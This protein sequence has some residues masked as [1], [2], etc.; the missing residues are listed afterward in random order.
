VLTV[1]AP[2]WAQHAPV[3]CGHTLGVHVVAAPWNVPGHSAAIPVEHVPSLMQHAPVGEARQFDAAHDT[4]TCHDEIPLHAE[5]NTDEH[6]PELRLQHA[7]STGWAHGFGWQFPPTAQLFGEAHVACGPPTHAPVVGLQH[8]PC[9][10]CGHVFVGWQLPPR[11]HAVPD[12][13]L[14]WIPNVHAPVCAL[15][16]VPSGGC[17]HG[18]GV[19][20]VFPTV[21]TVPLAVHW[22]CALITHPPVSV[23]QQLPIGGITHGFGLHTAPLVHTLGA[24]QLT[25][26]VVEHTPSCVQQL[27]LEGSGHTTASHTTDPVHTAGAAHCTWKFCV[28]VPNP[29]LQHAPVGGT[30]HGFGVQLPSCVQPAPPAHAPCVPIV[31]VPVS[32]QHAPFVTHGFG[33]PHVRPAVQKFC[34]AHDAWKYTTHPPAVVQHV[35]V[36]GHCPAPHAP[37][38]MNRLGNAHELDAPT[39]AHV[40]AVAQ[41][42]PDCASAGV[43]TPCTPA[44]MTSQQH[45]LRMRRS[46]M[47]PLAVYFA[48]RPRESPSTHRGRD[49][50]INSPGTGQKPPFARAARLRA[51]LERLQTRILPDRCSYWTTDSVSRPS[52]F[53]A[54]PQNRTIRNILQTTYS[55]SRRCPELPMSPARQSG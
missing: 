32:E 16:Q 20:V 43:P 27:P 30:T 11:L 33:G 13:Q 4:L 17:G 21:H 22:N 24:P 38:R 19:H 15:Q 10:G 49:D 44:T 23:V 54:R 12:P 37:P 8:V 26:I 14:V 9:G 41:H 52:E 34:E 50:H 18:F 1:Q 39:T 3:G 25:W 28:H 45:T 35:P 7:P 47:S 55:R 29:R 31:H 2:L 40:P 46:V 53:P 51:Q 42:A 36:D 5:Y 6:A 48:P